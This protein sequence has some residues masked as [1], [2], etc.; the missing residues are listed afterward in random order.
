MYKV[1]KAFTDDTDGR[2]VYR[3]GDIYPRPGGAEPTEERITYLSGSTNKFGRPLIQE[4]GR[5][6]KRKPEGE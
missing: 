2:H 1:L 5:S 4:I 3:T 6:K